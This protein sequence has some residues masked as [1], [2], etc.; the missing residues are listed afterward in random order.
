MR[1]IYKLI[2][3]TI[4]GLGFYGCGEDGGS[5]ASFESTG[6]TI[7]GCSDTT[8]I[9]DGYTSLSSGDTIVKDSDDTEVVIYHDSDGNKKICVST[10]SAYIIEG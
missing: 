7:I 2:M 9:P 4:L 1:R 5:D 6:S 10:G 8:D 3:I